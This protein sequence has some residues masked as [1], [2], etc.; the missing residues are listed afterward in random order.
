[1]K[2]PVVA[3]MPLWDEEKNSLWMLPGYLDGLRYAG[4]IPVIFPFTSD[5]EELSQLLDSCDGVLFTGGQDV[6][7]ALYGDKLFDDSVICCPKRDEMEG[8]VFR[9]AQKR[10][11]P[12]LG[13][14][15]GL[16]FLNAVYG[17]TLYQDLPTQHLTS[18]NHHGK[19]P[20]E[21]PDHEVDLVPGSPLQECLGKDVIEVNSYHH[22]GI[23]DL[24]KGLYPMAIAPDGLVEA[25]YDPQSRFLWAVQWHPE[26]S[27]GVDK[28]SREIFSAFVEA[29]K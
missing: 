15:R 7:P 6:S 8:I 16:Q 25:F 10:R 26:F 19:P 28:N 21:L 23:K 14:C 5:E 17:G 12:M 2:K 24:G 29:M 3:V 27:Y 11:L 20:Y 13:I 9:L 18:V 4:A 22:Q 1:M